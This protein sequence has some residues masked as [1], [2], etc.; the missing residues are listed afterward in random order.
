MTTPRRPDEDRDVQQRLQESWRGAVAR[1]ERDVADREIVSL[2]L[3]VRPRVRRA[4]VAVMGIAAFVVV[5]VAFVAVWSGGQLLGT[6]AASPRPAESQVVT[7]S[8][9]PTPTATASPADGGIPFLGPGQTFQPTVDGQPVVQVG[10]EADARIAA[11]ADDAPIYV[12]GWIVDPTGNWNWCS[13]PD[14][15]LG[16]DCISAQL[17]AGAD[18]GAALRIFSTTTSQPGLNATPALVQPVLIQV[19]VNDLACD[20]PECPRRPVLDRVLV[21]GATSVAP[22]LL[23]NAMQSGGISAEQAV[24]IA[25]HDVQRYPPAEPGQLPVLWVAA[26]PDALLEG[27]RGSQPDLWQWSVHLVSDDGRTEYNSIVGFVDGTVVG[28]DLGRS[29]NAADGVAPFDPSQTMPPDGISLEE[30]VAAALDHDISLFGEPLVLLSARA[31]PYA[32]LDEGR[33]P[34]EPDWVWAIDFSSDDGYQAYTAYVDY[35][36]GDV[37]GS[38]GGTVRETTVLLH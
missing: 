4:N 17:S 20:G 16:P 5:A 30:A 15:F 26:G 3:D 23:T 31:G 22:W 33:Y 11:A 7:G 24:E 29:E 19:H 8:F 9:A 37:R 1:A 21:Y 2:S 25:R 18:G 34:H 6:V 36:T 38:D 12:S 27:T 32:L 35:R 28:T 14:D 13:T 10:P